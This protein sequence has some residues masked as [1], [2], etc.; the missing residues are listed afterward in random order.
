MVKDLRQSKILVVDD[1]PAN[2]LLLEQFL[3]EEGYE[4]VISTTDSREVVNLYV[5][6]KVDMILLDI[7]MPYMDGIQVMEALKEVIGPDDY[8]PI[9]V[10]TAQTDM[11]TRQKALAMGARDFLTK[12]FQPW[13]VFQRIHNLLETRCFYMSQRSRANIL[14]DEVFK[15]TQEIQETQLEVV[16]RLGRAGEYRDNETGAHVVR[17]SKSCELLALKAGQDR[18]FAELILQAS[19]MHDVGK[20]G[21]PDNILLKPGRLTP[22][23]RGVMETHVEIG[24]DI[25]GKFDSP[26]LG[27]ARQIAA[28]HHEKWDGSGYPKKLK[29]EDIP[30]AGRIAAICD[31]FDALTSERPYKEAWPLEKAVNFLQDNAGSHFDPTL[32]KLFIE[33]IP[34]V[35]ALRE[36]HPDEEE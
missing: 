5:T 6:E 36:K 14:A 12:P 29:G 3:E 2:V 24:V 20:I 33:I 30:L 11:E 19:P 1:K 31:V 23:E 27:M 35:V 17:M 7:R 25:I 18:L 4:N 9:L 32:I 22:E 21:I 15:R 34:D 8:L 26:M 10:L 28:T 13:E 16:R